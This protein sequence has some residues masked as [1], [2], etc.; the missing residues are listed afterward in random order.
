MGKIYDEHVAFEIS[1]DYL[2]TCPWCH[3]QKANSQS[4]LQTF[5]SLKAS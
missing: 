2:E 5:D 3:E 1:N 4:M